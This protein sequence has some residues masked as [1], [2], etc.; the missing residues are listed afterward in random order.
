MKQV[1]PI[2][3]FVCSAALLGGQ[4]PLFAQTPKLASQQNSSPSSPMQGAKTDQAANKARV[5]ID[6]AIQALG[7][8]AF[9]NI[10][11]REQ[12]GRVWSFHAGRPSGGGAIFYSFSEFPDKER[13]ELTKDRDIAELFVGDKGYEI[14]YKGVHAQ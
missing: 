5:L 11:D 8:Q 4:E 1:F 12:Q 14:T 6:Q 9:L 7:G 3:I 13:I 10:R 2:L